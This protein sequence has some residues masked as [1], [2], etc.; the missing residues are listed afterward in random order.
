MAVSTMLAEQ[1]THPQTL[2]TIVTVTL[3]DRADGGLRVY[4]EDLP[5]LILSGP[6]RESVGEKIAPAIAALFEHKGFRGVIV[7]AAQ[8]LSA[9]LQK[10]SPRDVDL[11]VHHEQQFV[12]ELPEA[13]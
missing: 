5:G 4:S 6:D 8:P 11:H 10:A 9:V 3:E 12:V 13:A 2:L 1:M 7:R